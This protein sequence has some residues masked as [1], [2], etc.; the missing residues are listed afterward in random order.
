M[1]NTKIGTKEVQNKIKKTMTER[2]GVDC[3][4]KIPEVQ[5]QITRILTLK[6]GGRGAASPFIRAK[7]EDT[8]I[9]KYGIPHFIA[10]EQVKNKIEQSMIQKYGVRSNLL[11]PELRKDYD[12]KRTEKNKEKR[13]TEKNIQK[14]INEIKNRG[15]IFKFLKIIDGEPNYEIECPNCGNI[16]LWNE[17]IRYLTGREQHPFCKKCMSKGTSKQEKELLI[18]LKNIYTGEIK[19]HDRNVIFPKELDFYFPELNLAIEYDG[20]YW[21]SNN[22]KTLEKHRLCK[23]KNIEL[24]QLFENEWRN[25]ETRE[26]IKDVFLSVFVPTLNN[27]PLYE[28]IEY[29]NIFIIPKRFPFLNKYINNGFELIDEIETNEWY[30]ND[31][32]HLYKREELIIAIYD[33]N[34]TD[35]ENIKANGYDKV[36][37]LGSYILRK[38]S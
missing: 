28:S 9:K 26:K 5:D 22:K 33:N 21:H 2:Y 3:N 6:Y 30:F 10:S 11:V 24:I 31:R 1:K 34:L 36:F 23:E 16:W 29:D 4:L 37:D 13:N 8:S 35:Y 25:L 19:T 14:V 38:P 27:L 7:M 17:L 20:L 32:E 18:W 12:K 15:Y